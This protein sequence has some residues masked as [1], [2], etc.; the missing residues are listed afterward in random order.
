VATLPL[1]RLVKGGRVLEILITLF[2][3]IGDIGG[4]FFPGH[5]SPL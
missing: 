3:T 1:E 5:I 2:I 4:M